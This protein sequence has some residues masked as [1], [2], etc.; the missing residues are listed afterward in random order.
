MNQNKLKTITINSPAGSGNIFCQAIIAE[1]LFCNLRWVNHTIE[2]FDNNGINLFI[3]RNPYD[4]VASGVELNFN[5]LTIDEQKQFLKNFDYR[6]KDSIIAQKKQYDRFLNYSRYFDHV[7]PVDF[8]LL[9]KSPEEFLN[10]ISKKFDI[11]IKENICTSKDLLPQFS[12]N[13][14]FKNR[15]PREMSELRKKI[16][17]AVNSYTSLKNSYEDYSEYRDII[18]LKLIK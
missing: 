9:T 4:V 14:E 15:L 6:I 16:N 10:I 5:A 12:N 18:D 3:L 2:L 11:P 7:T 13:P 17:L 1:N 8:E